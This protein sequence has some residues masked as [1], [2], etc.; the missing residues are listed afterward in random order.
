ME[1][2]IPKCPSMAPYSWSQFLVA[3]SRK[4]RPS[5]LSLSQRMCR[6]TDPR[7]GL[8]LLPGGGRS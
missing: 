3:P 4:L 1:E 6:E 5:R 2:E 7:L 8:L